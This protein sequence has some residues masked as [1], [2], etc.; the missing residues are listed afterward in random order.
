M[1]NAFPSARLTVRGA[2][3]DAVAV[4]LALLVMMGIIL[5]NIAFRGY[6]NHVVV[7]NGNPAVY[8]LE[9]TSWSVVFLSI[10]SDEPV[11][12]CITN[13]GDASKALGNCVFLEEGITSTKKVWRFPTSGRFSM[14]I[15]PEGDQKAVVAVKIVPL[16]GFRGL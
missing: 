14:V 9:G 4:I 10:N 13:G 12:V 7:E 6:S 15:I 16:F 3:E 11:T 8:Q 1:R 2:R 5:S